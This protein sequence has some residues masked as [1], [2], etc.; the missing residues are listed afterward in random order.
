M[1]RVGLYAR[2]AGRAREDL[3][4]RF[5]APP[6]HSPP[7]SIQLVPAREAWGLPSDELFAPA[8]LPLSIVSRAER[9]KVGL[10]AFLQRWL[11]NDLQLTR[12]DRA[13]AEKELLAVIGRSTPIE[14][15]SSAD[16]YCV[17]EGADVRA[18]KAGTP[19]RSFVPA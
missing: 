9:M 1:S 6:D 14:G 19:R 18:M 13:T 3:V 7:D 16:S 17:P 2:L 12:W 15:W 5:A 10:L 8:G 4:K 11:P